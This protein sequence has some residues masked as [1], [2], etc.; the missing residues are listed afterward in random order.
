MSFELPSDE[1][2]RLADAGGGVVAGGAVDAE[3]GQDNVHPKI[4]L[5]RLLIALWL[6]C[7]DNG[8]DNLHES[9]ALFECD[10]EFR[11]QRCHS[12]SEADTA[13]SRDCQ[14]LSSL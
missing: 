6:S 1:L 13:D 4:S 7:P 9:K 14:M 12:F 2:A 10:E 5:R 8:Y 3:D 11:I